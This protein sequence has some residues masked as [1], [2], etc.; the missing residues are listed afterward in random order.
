MHF[1]NFCTNATEYQLLLK[2]LMLCPQLKDGQ[3]VS[4]ARVLVIT[5]HP[6]S[7]WV[8]LDSVCSLSTISTTLATVGNTVLCTQGNLY[9][10]QSTDTQHIM[11][12]YGW[13][14][15]RPPSRMAQTKQ[16]MGRAISPHGLENSD[17]FG[18]QHTAAFHSPTVVCSNNSTLGILVYH[19][20][21]YQHTLVIA[22]H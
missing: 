11:F 4:N 12:A 21:L 17:G 2:L 20:P 3:L 19:V 1:H 13:I 7:A 5:V 22:L 14:N 16:V 8:Q 9:T 15:H 18:N 6:L 10:I